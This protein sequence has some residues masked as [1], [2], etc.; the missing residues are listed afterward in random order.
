M[1]TRATIAVRRPD[2]HYEAAYLHFDG[3]PS[4]TGESLKQHYSTRSLAEGLVAS[5]DLR[6]IDRGT[7]AVERYSNRNAPAVLPTKDAL[8][9]FARNCDA[10]YLYVFDAGTWSCVEL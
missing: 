3:Y 10:Q 8:I 9:D 7:G 6:C 1:S 4:H 2:E 5:G